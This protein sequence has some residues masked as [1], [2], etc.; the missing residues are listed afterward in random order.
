MRKDIVKK[1]NGWKPLHLCDKCLMPVDD[2]LFQG[3]PNIYKIGTTFFVGKHW[4]HFD[5]K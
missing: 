4:R 1:R 5:C 3:A 2:F